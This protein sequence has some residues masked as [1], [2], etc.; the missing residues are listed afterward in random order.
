[1]TSSRRFTTTLVG[2]VLVYFAYG[3]RRFSLGVDFTDEGVYVAWPLRTLFGEPAF[4]GDP[5]L[6]M[7]P[8]FNAI[9][10]LYRLHP[11]ITLY[12]LR[13][14][15][16]IIHLGAFAALATFLF[17]LTGFTVRSL[18]LASLPFLICH[19]FGLA[20]PS[21]NSTSSDFFLIA[22]SFLGLAQFGDARRPFLL[23]FVAGLGLFVATFAHPALGLVAA[24]IG[25][26]EVLRRR[27]IQNCVRLQPTA[28]NFGF[29]ILVAGW[30]AYLLHFVTTGALA[31]WL[32]RSAVYRSARVKSL[33]GNVGRFFLDLLSYPF[34]FDGTAL[35]FFAIAVSCA[36]ASCVLA[37]RGNLVAAGNA[38]AALAL[39]LMIAMVRTFSFHGDHLPVA[40]A[41]AGLVVILVHALPVCESVFKAGPD[42]RLL[43]AGSAL[44]AVLYATI[45]YFFS[46]LRSWISG[47]LALPFAFAVGLALL[48]RAASGRFAPLIRLLS[49][50]VLALAVACVAREHYRSIYRDAYPGRLTA[51]FHTPKFRHLLSTPERVQ[52]V[53]MLYDYLRPKLTRGESLLA[54]DDCPML[55]FLFDARPG[56]GLTWAARYTQTP[57][58]LARLDDEF[59]SH[60]LPRYA[61]RTLV[62]LSHPT[63]SLAPRTSYSDYPLNATVITRYELEHTVF[64]FEVWRLKPGAP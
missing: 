18:L 16:W 40:F 22:L 3:V 19:I 5:L 38:G 54:F 7:R 9:S 31:I 28:S 61:I 37:R 36:V 62:D 45:T 43:F 60:P 48:L 25:L 13:L 15:G 21:Y 12:E 6:A 59:R 24:V 46:P 2:F 23:H 1:M 34:S 35:V 26:N 50:A 63:W 52:S 51:R 39:L 10:A 56:Y 17:R 30:L 14:L 41:M 8:M 49:T 44:G 42:L 27:L 55:Y 4:A 53:D 11:D 47:I 57:A 58:S 29:L 20:P 33:E 64:P 32:E